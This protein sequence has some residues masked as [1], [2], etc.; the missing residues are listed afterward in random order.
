M[1][2]KKVDRVED[3]E[4]LHPPEI[5]DPTEVYDHDLDAETVNSPLLLYLWT[6]LKNGKSMHR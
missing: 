5:Q 4:T 1:T 6:M 2:I 3:L